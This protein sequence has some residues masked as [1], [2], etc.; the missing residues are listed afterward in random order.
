MPLNK[1]AL[2]EKIAAALTVDQNNPTHSAQEVASDLAD[3]IEAFVKSGDVT[4][5]STSVTVTVQ[6][7]GSATAQT[8]TGTGTGTQTGFGR[9]E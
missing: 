3:A 7:T 1:A 2:A 5:V 9:I 4:G 8:G 6:T